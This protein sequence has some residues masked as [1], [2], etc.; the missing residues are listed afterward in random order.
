MWSNLNKQFIGNE[1]KNLGFHLRTSLRFPVSTEKRFGP[2]RDW[3]RTQIAFCL[4]SLGIS[5]F[6]KQF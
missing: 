5:A 4:S 1:A 6:P 2:H 3:E